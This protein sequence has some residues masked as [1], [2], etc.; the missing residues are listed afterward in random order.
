MAQ[1]GFRTLSA[2]AAALLLFACN[3]ATAD[4]NEPEKTSTEPWRLG[5]VKADLTSAS[6]PTDTPL[7]QPE[8]IKIE[9]EKAAL[10]EEG[11]QFDGLKF[12]AGYSLSSNDL[13]FGGLSGLDFLAPD[14][15]LAISDAGYLLWLDLDED[16]L[17]PISGQVST[18]RDE[19]GQVLDGK[20]NTDAEGLSVSDDL[21]LVSFERNH[22]VL[23]FAPDICGALARGASVYTMSDDGAAPRIKSNN[24]IE[25]L[26]LDPDGGLVIGLEARRD[27]RALVSMT[28][29]GGRAEFKP[30][31]PVTDQR[32]LT[33]AD[34]L[35][36]TDGSTRLYSLHR[37]YDPI[38]GVR[39]SI[40]ETQMYADRA[41]NW[42]LNDPRE[43]ATMKA[44]SFIDNFEAISAQELPDGQVRLFIVSD[45]NFSQTQH[46]LLYVFDTIAEEQTIDALA[47]P[48]VAD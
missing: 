28:P 1:S 23:A 32:A 45:D 8:K 14:R 38:R 2:F 17:T 30:T 35:K 37:A 48:A 20:R 24:G 29:Q 19:K 46:T 27:G 21:V 25:A 26:S 41:G 47:E 15:M 31:L 12:V 43:I 10:G 39:I 5:D 6:C 3:A 22:R 9:A 16:G 13:R 34:V 7:V 18:L 42:R 11:V 44:P 36:T 40:L 4:K 33:G